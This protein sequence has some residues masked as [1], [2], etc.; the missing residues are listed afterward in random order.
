MKTQMLT[1]ETRGPRVFFAGGVSWVISISNS[2][3]E[4]WRLDNMTRNYDAYR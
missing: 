4:D 3:S 1:R 2:D